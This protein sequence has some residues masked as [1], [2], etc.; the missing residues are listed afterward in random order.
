MQSQVHFQKITEIALVPKI[1]KE[2]KNTI[3]YSKEDLTRTRYD[4][5]RTVSA[6]RRGKPLET[7]MCVRGLEHLQSNAQMEYRRLSKA[8]VVTAVLTEQAWQ[9]AAGIIDSDTIAGASCHFSKWAKEMA[10]L[11]GASD[12]VYNS[13]Q[14]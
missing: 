2:A 12:A 10:L 7:N 6:M 4:V 13:S 3:W 8:L 11:L 1:P 14:Q 9:R 5:A